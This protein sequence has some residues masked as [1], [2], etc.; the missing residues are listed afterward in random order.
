[1]M[2]FFKLKLM[3]IIS[4]MISVF[5]L[6][7]CS[8]NNSFIEKHGMLAVR[9]NKL[10]NQHG[11][12]PMLAGPSF[13]WSTSGW[14]GSEYYNENVVT[15]FKKEW[16]ASVVRAAIG[17]NSPGGY[18]DNPKENIARAEALIDAAIEHG[19]YVILD[20]HTHDA[21]TKPELAKEFFTY[22]ATKYGKHPN[23]I[24]EIYNEPLDTTEWETEIKPYSQNIIKVIRAIDPD[25]LIIIGSQS[26]SQDVDKT[27]KS[28]IS[29]HE[30][31]LYSLHFYAGTHGEGLRVKATQAIEQGL[32]LIITEWGS[33]NSNGDGDINHENTEAWVNFMRRNQ[34]SQLSWA[35]NDK[36][37][38]TSIFRPD[39]P[40]DTRITDKDLTPSGKLAQKYTKEWTAQTNLIQ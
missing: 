35:V 39:T 16:N 34:L 17:V 23:L 8:N 28:P 12:P 4:L 14:G 40:P 31:I 29:G 9:G 7:S 22:F 18:V 21:E 15:Y 33:V 30:N 19:L 11:N 24:Y 26:W 1:M 5:I 27:A 25:N 20:W 6:A 36:P 13:F 3:L 2:S 32:A 10:V 38:S 37:E